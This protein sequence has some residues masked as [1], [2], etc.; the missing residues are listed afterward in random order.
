MFDEKKDLGG[1]VHYYQDHEGKFFKR[2]SAKRCVEDVFLVGQ[3]QG[4][5]G[6][7]GLHW[8]Y[9]SSGNFC[10]S[11]N[12]FDPKEGGCSGSTPPDHKNYISPV[13]M[14]NSHYSK[15]GSE[16]EEVIDPEELKMLAWDW[17]YS[18]PLPSQ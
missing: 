1:T 10:W 16:W 18:R 4:V 17:L 2:T 15:F 11:D 14:C 12:E 6:H 7:N 3:C 8:R 5:E 9:D 13:E